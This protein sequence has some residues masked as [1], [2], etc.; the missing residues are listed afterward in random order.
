MY[1]Y[2]MK[3]AKKKAESVESSFHILLIIKMFLSKIIVIT[4]ENIR[5]N[6]NKIIKMSQNDTL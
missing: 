3:R 6:V 5:L 2:E 1:V 4:V